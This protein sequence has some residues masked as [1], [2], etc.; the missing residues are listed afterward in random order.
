M[1]FCGSVK[2]SGGRK[3][4]YTQLLRMRKVVM[5]INDTVPSSGEHPIPA[6][7]HDGR[8]VFQGK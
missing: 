3:E 8:L 7:L 4:E 2:R 6:A 1:P 5:M